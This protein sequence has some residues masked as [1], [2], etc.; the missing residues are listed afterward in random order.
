MKANPFIVE[1]L[2]EASK[3][4]RPSVCFQP[5]GSDPSKLVPG[6][7]ESI[8][9]SNKWGYDISGEEAYQLALDALAGGYAIIWVKAPY[10]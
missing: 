2:T 8:H 10:R 1:T 6:G 5:S 4:P 9:L 7:W 3:V